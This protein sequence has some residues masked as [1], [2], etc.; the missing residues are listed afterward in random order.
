MAQPLEAS[1]SSRVSFN[2]FDEEDYDDPFQMDDE[3]FQTELLAEENYNWNRFAESLQPP[4]ADDLR[5]S[6]PVIPK[7]IVMPVQTKVMRESTTLET[8][9]LHEHRSRLHAQS[10]QIHILKQNRR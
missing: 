2:R 6:M 7:A 3:P 8:P 10:L 9:Q 5:A 1:S 4:T